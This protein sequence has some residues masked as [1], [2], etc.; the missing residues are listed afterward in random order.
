MNRREAIHALL[1][2]PQVAR[3]T[4]ATI[5]P[6]DAIVVECD[7]PLTHEATEHLRAL[8]KQIWPGHPVLI[9]NAGVRI[10]VVES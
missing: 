4:T 6:N 5:K 1:A 10:K 9:C 2:L 3:V 7:R 8:V